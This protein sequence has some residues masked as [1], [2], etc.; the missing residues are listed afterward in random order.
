MNSRNMFDEL[1]LADSP[2]HD[3]R[4]NSGC[5]RML[6]KGWCTHQVFSL[7][8]SCQPDILSYL[9]SLDSSSVR[10]INHDRC[11]SEPHCVAYNVDMSNYMSRHVN[12]ECTCVHVS[13]PGQELTSI[14]E[15][16]EVPLISVQRSTDEDTGYLTLNVERR[17]KHVA[18]TAISHV[19][20]DGLGNPHGNS[21][22]ACQLRLLEEQLRLLSGSSKVSKCFHSRTVSY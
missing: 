14:I 1:P 2:L 9:A 21:L 12:S 10:Q 5:H 3:A 6:S 7:T 16:N 11:S 19:W 8:R 17:Q 13:I 20:I 22:P 15:Q 4:R 18:Y